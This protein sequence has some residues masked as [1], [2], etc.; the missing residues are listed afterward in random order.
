MLKWFTQ[1]L[2]A[3]AYLDSCHIVHCDLKLK[4]IL[5]SKDDNL[6]LCDFG[7]AIKLTQDMTMTFQRGI[8][9]SKVHVL[10]LPYACTLL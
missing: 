2:S 6:K 8:Y 1:L 10:Y 7:S 5:L 4:N 3:L 9:N